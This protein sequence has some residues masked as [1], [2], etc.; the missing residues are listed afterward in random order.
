MSIELLSNDSLLL[1]LTDV[2]LYKYSKL[3]CIIELLKVSKRWYTLLLSEKSKFL[4]N[5]IFQKQ[6]T[7][8]IIS[9]PFNLELSGGNALFYL[10]NI[11]NLRIEECNSD[12]MLINWNGYIG[13][14][15]S[16]TKTYIFRNP[17][18]NDNFKFPFA[19]SVQVCT[20]R[21]LLVYQ[22]SNN[23]FLLWDIN[24]VINGNLKPKIL[25][26]LSK[27]DESYIYDFCIKYNTI[28]FHVVLNRNINSFNFLYRG[29]TIDLITNQI[30]V[31]PGTEDGLSISDISKYFSF[32]NRLLITPKRMLEQGVKTEQPL[33]CLTSEPT[34][35]RDL[36]TGDETVENWPPK[37]VVDFLSIPKESLGK[38]LKFPTYYLN[39]QDYVVFV[40]N[41][42]DKSYIVVY[43]LIAKKIA[44]KA[45]FNHKIEDIFCLGQTD[46]PQ[47]NK[48]LG[49]FMIGFKSND[50]YICKVFS[51]QTGISNLEMLTTSENINSIVRVGNCIYYLKILTGNNFGN[52]WNMQISAPPDSSTSTSSDASESNQPLRNVIAST[53]KIPESKDNKAFEGFYDLTHGF[54]FNSKGKRNMVY[55]V[56]DNLNQPEKRRDLT[57][58]EKEIAKTIGFKIK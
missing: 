32:T 39:E 36:I 11:F 49:H 55:G 54:I 53:F 52:I 33:L 51:T 24:M 8:E 26:I 1:I 12:N 3:S 57:I 47:I 17:T 13:S 50:C 38:F 29:Y 56:V 31:C 27:P 16:T 15:D 9:P 37:D 46:L 21:E 2:I 58:S 34:V 10:K 41:K 18:T 30:T 23:Y 4:W 35:F 48:N 22:F 7:P 42:K 25:Q 6:L 14:F 45:I 44:W 5:D 40:I 19:L 20:E 28:Y 43:D